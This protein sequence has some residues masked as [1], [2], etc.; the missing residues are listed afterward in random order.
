LSLESEKH[1]LLKNYVRVDVVIGQYRGV[2]GK[3]DI[4]NDFSSQRMASSLLSGLQNISEGTA[5]G[6]AKGR[7]QGSQ[8]KVTC[9]T[10]L[11]TL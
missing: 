5:E 10:Q 1:P 2:N 9:Y 11:S 7:L 8:E 6:L 4:N 3:E